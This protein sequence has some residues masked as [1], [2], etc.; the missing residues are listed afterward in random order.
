V[1]NTI[2]S[3]TTFNG[4]LQFVPKLDFGSPV[5]TG[6][7]V[8]PV[9]RTIATL[10]D[11][12][13]GRLV[14]ITGVTFTSAGSAFPSPNFTS[15]SP[16]VTAISDGTAGT[17]QNLFGFPSG[18]T[19]P[20][21]PNTVTGIVQKTLVGTTSTITVASRNLADI[22][23]TGSAALTIVTDKTTLNEG[24]PGPPYPGEAAVTITRTGST[25]A[26]LTVDLSVSASLQLMVDLDDTLGYRALPTTVTILAGQ[27]TKTVY[28]IP[29]NDAVYTGNR[30]ATFTAAASGYTSANQVFAIVEDESP[31]NSYAS[32]AATNAPGQTPSQDYDKDGVSNG[33][34][35]FFGATGSTFTPNPQLV[36]NKITFPKDASATGATG[37]TGTIQT[38]PDLVTW[39][40][41]TADTS[42]AGFISYTLPTGQGK[43]FVRL[44]VVVAP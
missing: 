18:T 1:Q 12:D 17:F 44:N 6:N 15:G 27:A 20:A 13:Q 11:S 4:Q 34:E 43:I 39:T 31:G 25:A 8:T 33:V 30:N 2:G 42:V 35:Y 41:V 16:G 24:T 32:W 36:G 29:T 3:L 21:G 37:A 19:I 40:P 23:F 28:L 9:S 5:S 38:S 7:A 26:A 10:T 22:V 14:T